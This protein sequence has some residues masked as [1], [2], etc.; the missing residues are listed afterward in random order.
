MNRI[1]IAL[2]FFLNA[3]TGISQN[4]LLW[5]ISGN[6]LKTSSYLYGTFHSK[7][8]R[9]HEFGDSVL[10]KLNQVKTIVVENIDIEK[11]NSVEALESVMM[12]EEELENLLNKIDYELV[13]EEALNRMGMAGLLFNRMKPIFTSIIA[14]ELNSL[15]EMPYTVDGFFKKESQRL[16]K[17]LIGLESVEE[18][19]VALDNIPLK[20]QAAM[21][22]DFF[23][24]FDEKMLLMDSVIQLY[25]SQKIDELYSFY[26]S[27]E[28]LPVS[29]DESLVEERN[30]QF[31]ERLI[32]LIEKESIFCAVGALHLPGET[33]LINS[34]KKQGYILTPVYSNYSE[35]KKIIK[36]DKEWFY[37]QN[38]T[39]SLTMSFKDDPYFSTNK[40]AVTDK[41]SVQMSNY[42]LIDSINH[43]KYTASVGILN[44][45]TTLDNIANQLKQNE[46]WKKVKEKNI[47]YLG[48][49]SKELEF[50]VAPQI[51]ITCKVTIESNKIYI[52]SVTGS[53]S[54]I[55]SNLADKFFNNISSFVRDSD[56]SLELIGAIG[57]IDEI[58]EKGDTVN[59][60]NNESKINVTIYDVETEDVL[61]RVILARDDTVYHSLP[62]N[63]FYKLIFHCE[64][65][66]DKGFY[67]DT[68]N[69]SQQSETFNYGAEFPYQLNLIKSLK[70]QKIKIKDTISFD[71]EKDYFEIRLN[72]N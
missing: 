44:Q 11:T 69:V 49:I 72:N 63:G 54:A 56:I 51:S 47:S 22:V 5:E 20:E 18:A 61:D 66:Q 16:D 53:K 1:L 7:D 15:Q 55:H 23:N 67:V 64:G 8:S 58:T 35:K 43:I 46:G 62:F 50:N 40:I 12:E 42:F 36:G 14:V 13:Q 9:A 71:K 41:D 26:K 45:E 38:D 33:G 19:M 31:T 37:Y 30:K 57:L 34:L 2:I 10:V 29:F 65:Y 17:K 27:K 70:P 28:D 6:G 4:T 21:L 24:N 3:F 39:M 68:R 32:P 48:K 60:S 52:I 59:S 25:Q